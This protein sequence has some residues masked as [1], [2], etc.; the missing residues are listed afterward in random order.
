M[1]RLAD[2]HGRHLDDVSLFKPAGKSL[3]RKREEVHVLKDC[4]ARVAATKSMAFPGSVAWTCPR[5]VGGAGCYRDLELRCLLVAIVVLLL[6]KNTLACSDLAYDGVEHERA[7]EKKCNGTNDT[8][9]AARGPQTRHNGSTVRK[10]QNQKTGALEEIIGSASIRMNHHL[11]LTMSRKCTPQ[12][13]V[14]TPE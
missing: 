7:L 12:A 6:E 5:M 1:K 13:R 9:L 2:G 11:M 8:C 14:H 10:Q 4:D 3:A